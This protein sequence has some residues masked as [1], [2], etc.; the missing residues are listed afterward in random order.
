MRPSGFLWIP[1]VYL[2][3][4]EGFHAFRVGLRSPG[5]S[6]RCLRMQKHMKSLRF[7]ASAGG[8]E[9]TPGSGLGWLTFEVRSVP[10]SAPSRPIG[11]SRPGEG[12]GEGQIRLR[13]TCE[14]WSARA[15]HEGQSV[16]IAIK[17]LSA[18]V[19]RFRELDRSE[20][21]VHPRL[22]EAAT[23]PE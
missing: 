1:I 22:L 16:M 20:F 4:S 12:R 10:K 5:R 18:M 23:A 3:L 14:G 9:A 2:E 7:E 19:E 13:R 8:G 15:S 21:S 17:T 6:F 11:I